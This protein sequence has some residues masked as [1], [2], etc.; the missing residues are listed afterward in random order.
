MRWKS[1]CPSSS[2]SGSASMRHSL[3]VPSGPLC[4]TRWMVWLYVSCGLAGW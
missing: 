3:P 4:R 2:P 1:D